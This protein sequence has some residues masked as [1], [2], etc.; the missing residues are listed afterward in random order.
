MTVLGVATLDDLKVQLLDA[1]RDGRQR[2]AMLV[3]LFISDCLL[4]LRR[5]TDVLEKCRQVR[6]LFAELGT[7]FEV[8]QAILNEAAALTGLRDFSAARASLAEARTLFEKVKAS[9]LC[10]SLTM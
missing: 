4:Q 9:G 1:G 2:H 6:A 3:E 5:F 8:G 10:S 7:R